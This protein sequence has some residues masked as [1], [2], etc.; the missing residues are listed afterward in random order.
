MPPSLNAVASSLRV[1]ASRAFGP[2]PTAEVSAVHPLLHLASLAGV[3]AM[4]PN[5]EIVWIDR[6]SYFLWT[7]VRS[8]V[9]SALFSV[10]DLCAM[11]GWILLQQRT[12]GNMDLSWGL[13][14]IVM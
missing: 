11:E 8:K 10:I 12:P 6:P 2:M 13:G 4:P 3:S 7:I 5:N 1:A 9:S 14:A